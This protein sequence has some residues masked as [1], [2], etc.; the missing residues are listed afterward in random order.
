MRLNW[1]TSY[2]RLSDEYGRELNDRIR[3]ITQEQPE[4]TERVIERLKAQ[5]P[6][7]QD[8]TIEDFRKN[9][10]LRGMVKGEIMRSHPNHFEALNNKEGAKLQETKTRILAIEPGFKF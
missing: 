3:A 9:Q 7:F 8:K 6:A 1:T 5:F 4:E 10:T 2:E